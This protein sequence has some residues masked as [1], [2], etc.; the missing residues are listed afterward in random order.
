MDI[1]A[2]EPAAQQLAQLMAAS[3]AGEAH[4]VFRNS[5]GKLNA[6]IVLAEGEKAV[7]VMEMIGNLEQLWGEKPENPEDTDCECHAH[8]AEKGC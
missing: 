8:G 6:C 4:V 3:N 1:N 5:E 7:D 2:V